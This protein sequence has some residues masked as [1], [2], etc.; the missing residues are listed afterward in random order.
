MKIVI[1]NSNITYNKFEEQLS[2][3]FDIHMI[4]SKE[5]LN[6]DDLKAIEP[7]YIFFPHWSFYIPKKIY[8][9]FKCVVFHMTDLPY[10]RGGSPLQNLILRG[11]SETKL[12]AIEVVKEID[13]GRIYMKEK[14][15]LEGTAREIFQRCENLIIKMIKSIGT[16]N[17]AP[18]EQVGQI[19]M[20]ERRKPEQSNV[21][22]IDDLNLLH[23]YIRMLDADGYPN[24]FLE[25]ETLRFE[26]TKSEINSK[27]ISAHVRIFK[28]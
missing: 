7:A 3:L 28:K 21:E 23:D 25:T 17:S 24:A 5:E 6:F 15:S 14:L 12:S 16:N 11:H 10:G 27:E 13:A 8:D 19:T 20:F 2:S 22:D 4:T 1:A 26:F 18:I 9:H